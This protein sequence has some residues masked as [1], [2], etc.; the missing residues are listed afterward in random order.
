MKLRAAK[1]ESRT[2]L[3]ARLDTTLLV[4]ARHGY[5]ARFITIVS[6]EAQQSRMEAD[7]IPAPLQHSTFQ[8]IV[9]QDTWNALKC[10]EGG[11]VPAQEVLHSGIK[12]E[13]QEDLPGMAQHHHERH[14]R[15]PR[16]ADLQM[17]EVR[18]VH[19]ALLA[20]QA[21]QPQIRLGRT[22]RTVAGNEVAKMPAEQRLAVRQKDVAPLVAE[23]EVWMRAARSKMSRH[24]DV[25][26]AMDYMLKRWST[27]TRFLNDGRICLTN[28]AAERALRGVALGRKAWLFAGS[29]RGGERA[30]AMYSL[31][32]TC[33]LNDVDLRAWLADVL[34]RIADHPA[35]RLDE[36][37]PWHWSR[38]R[39]ERSLA[40]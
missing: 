31:V 34:A 23:L 12:E 36:L 16:A 7:R 9:E 2:Y 30:A 39:E 17:A 6:G 26:K 4:A 29:N 37:L 40:A 14:Q 10:L 15:T 32:V 35:S 38:R 22:T 5:R 19:L 24:A 20:R 33:K 25:A 21:A 27:F 3:I 1:N 28:N 13:A 11:N 8:I 18:P